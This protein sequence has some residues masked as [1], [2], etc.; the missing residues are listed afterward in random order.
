[1]VGGEKRWLSSGEA[2]RRL[3][4]AICTGQG[5]KSSCGREKVKRMSAVG[6]TGTT[7]EEPATSS[8]DPKLH[9]TSFTWLPSSSLID[10]D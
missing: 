9:N 10:I 2:S 1:M 7:L 6:M 4:R 3:V 8:M 5:T